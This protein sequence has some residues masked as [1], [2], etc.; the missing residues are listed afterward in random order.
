M[1]QVSKGAPGAQASEGV[2]ATF[3]D[4][5]LSNFF[6]N[7]P[8]VVGVGRALFNNVNNQRQEHESSSCASSAS[9]PPPPPRQELQRNQLK[10]AASAPNTVA[11][12]RVTRWFFHVTQQQEQRGD[13][14]RAAEDM[15]RG[16]FRLCVATKTLR[17][18]VLVAGIIAGTFYFHMFLQ[19]EYFFR[20]KSNVMR[21][22]LFRQSYMCTHLHNVIYAIENTYFV[23]LKRVVDLVLLPLY[24]A[25]MSTATAAAAAATGG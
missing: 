2:G 22:V 8:H 5:Q 17:S 10:P 11:P 18:A 1:R 25:G 9:P 12:S 6:A 4:L 16:F 15:T 7:P 21:V 24:N 19:R 14:A 13:Y 23:G 20:C 3:S